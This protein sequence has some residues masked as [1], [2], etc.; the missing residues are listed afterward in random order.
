MGV[1]I[2]RVEERNGNLLVQ[3]QI[4]KKADFALLQAIF[5]DCVS[6]RLC[7][8]T[9]FGLDKDYKTVSVLKYPLN[10]VFDLIYEAT[11][12]RV[13]LTYTPIKKPKSED[14]QAA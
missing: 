2:H 8:E 7:I 5:R 1:T 14:E 11:T 13:G 9:R 6:S 12:G 4:E 3:A 10:V